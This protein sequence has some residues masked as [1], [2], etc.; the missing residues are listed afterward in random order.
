VKGKEG[1]RDQRPEGR[2]RRSENRNWKKIGI[3]IEKSGKV[4]QVESYKWRCRDKNGRAEVR[5]RR[6]GKQ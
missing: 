4:S 5:D 2:S 3:R 6:S 1:N